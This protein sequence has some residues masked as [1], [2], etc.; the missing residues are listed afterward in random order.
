LEQEKL[1]V[2][3]NTG[4]KNKKMSG[5]FPGTNTDLFRVQDLYSKINF[6]KKNL[7]NP[8]PKEK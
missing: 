7:R 3:S 6:R 4:K 2:I 8:T 5:M 1:N